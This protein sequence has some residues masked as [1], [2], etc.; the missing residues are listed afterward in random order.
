MA[1][2]KAPAKKKTVARKATIK[3]MKAT[4]SSLP[5]G[6]DKYGKRKKIPVKITIMAELEDSGPDQGGGGP[7]VG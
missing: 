6:T 7:P 5:G 2:K 3:S 4:L 1:K